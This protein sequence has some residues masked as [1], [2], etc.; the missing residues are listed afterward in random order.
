MNHNEQII[1]QAVIYARVSSTKQVTQG[2]GLNSQNTR[3]REY[4]KYK[5]YEVIETFVDDM[6]GSLITRPGMQAM[7]K[8]LRKR[9]KL[10]TVVIIDD[11][12]RLARGIE[13]HLQLRSALN[14][15][16][17][18]LESPSIEFGEDSDS[19][20][21][22]NLLASVSQHQRQK[23]G[24]QTTNRMRARSLGGYWVFQAPIGYQYVR[25]AGHGKV[26]VRHEPYATILAEALEGYAAGRFETQVE[27]KRFLESCSEFPKDTKSGEIRNQRVTD[28]LTR[29]IYAGYIEVANW[30]VSLRK[31]QHEGLISFE[32]Y[33]KI[34]TR[35][36][37]GAKAPARKNIS[38]DFPL[39]GFILCL[40]C[41]KPLTACWSKSKTGKKHPYYLCPTKECVSYR[42]SIRRNVLEGEFADLLHTLQP[43]ERLF[44]LAKTMFKDIWAQRQAQADVRLA[45]LKRKADKIDKQIEGLLD[46]IVEANNP[47]VVTAYE[48]RI[49]KLEQ[50]RLLIAEKLQNSA[51]PAHTF[52]DLFELAFK[53]LQNPWK[54]WDSGQLTLQRMVLRL[55]FSDR[56]PY[57]RKTGLRTPN[58]SLPFNMLDSI[59]MGKSEM[60]TP[61]GFEPLTYRL[62]I[63]R[64]INE[65]NMV[66][67]FVLVMCTIK[68]Q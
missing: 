19:I 44:D 14:D 12:S 28:W 15:A 65:F 59:Q 40:D 62:G 33:Q 41:Q 1:K 39:R 25:K 23:T 61:R 32:T 7:L 50:E 22:E 60:V 66:S 43:T 64:F 53:F 46:R 8:F 5:G 13:A 57:C 6:S 27:V 67:D 35:L 9:K 24:E 2:D 3:C 52:E 20:L 68:C 30:N 38:A 11:I 4:A 16:E 31:G 51:R 63:S 42:K 21:V 49:A 45:S 48:A 56:I 36:T 47:T 34:Q 18:K 55:A 10:G 37:E 54:L 58:L 17:G 26:L 29:P